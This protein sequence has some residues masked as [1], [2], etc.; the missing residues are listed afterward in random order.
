MPQRS[1]PVTEIKEDIDLAGLMT[2]EEFEKI[3]NDMIYES[4]DQ[5]SPLD[6]I[7][8]FCEQRGIEIESA[9]SMLTANLRVQVEDEFMK[10]HMLPHR[11]TVPM[12]I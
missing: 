4:D 6:A 5:I 12:E 11:A 9:A 3:I 10:L 7:V 2:A 8:E 1:T